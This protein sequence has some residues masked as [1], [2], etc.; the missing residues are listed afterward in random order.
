MQTGTFIRNIK[1]KKP[2]KFRLEIK[3]QIFLAIIPF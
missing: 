1:E 3:I 2:I